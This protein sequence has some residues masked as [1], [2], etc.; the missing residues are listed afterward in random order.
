MEK[1]VIGLC[2]AFPLFGSNLHRT[3]HI[4]WTFRDRNSDSNTFTPH[5]CAP[6]Y[7]PIRM[8]KCYN[9]SKREFFR[10]NLF[11]L[12]FLSLFTFKIKST[13]T[14]HR[15]PTSS[16]TWSWLPF[17]ILHIENRA[18]VNIGRCR[19]IRIISSVLFRHRLTRNQSVRQSASEPG[20]QRKVENRKCKA[21]R[22]RNENRRTYFWSIFFLFHCV[23]C[24]LRFVEQCNSQTAAID[25]RAARKKVC[26]SSWV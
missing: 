13:T 25:F 21:V 5:L 19:Y 6:S 7:C 22:E 9:N 23:A 4:S 10:L 15:H 8:V 17:F 12:C 14:Q 16:N 24:C 18:W 26:V 1:K 20:N 3:H 2:A 11:R